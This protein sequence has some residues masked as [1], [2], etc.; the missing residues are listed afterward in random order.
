MKDYGE[1]I[2]RMEDICKVFDLG[3]GK[4]LAASDHVNISLHR[5]ETL[6]VVG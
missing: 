2:L 3:G 1:E 6:G 4:T 5:G